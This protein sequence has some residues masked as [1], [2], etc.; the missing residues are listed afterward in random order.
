MHLLYGILLLCKKGI[1]E[2]C[3][4]NILHHNTMLYQLLI[5]YGTEYR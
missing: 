3:H 2:S 5:P 4:Y 1:V